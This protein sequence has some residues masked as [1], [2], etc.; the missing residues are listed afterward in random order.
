MRIRSVTAHAFGA[1]EDTTLEFPH[2]L[3]IVVGLNGTGKS[4]WHAAIYAALTGIPAEVVAPVDRR[5]RRRRPRTGS[6]WSVSAEI[7]ADGR[8]VRIAQDLN[9]PHACT[10][11][12]ADTEADLASSIR[13]DGGLDA[14]RWLGLDRRSFAATAYVEQAY[15]LLA[16]SEDS[17][18]KA[19]QRAIASGGGETTVA[20][21]Q[22]RIARH[23]SRVVGE[24]T[25][26]YSPIGR[27]LA[28]VQ[29]TSA[30]QAEHA[31]LS[32]QHRDQQY[33][34]TQ[35]DQE[36]VRAHAD[37]TTG[38]IA[39]ARAAVAE[40]QTR[41]DEA[42]K[43][44]RDHAEAVAF[45]AAR[46]AADPRVEDAAA[47]YR[48]ALSASA[49]PAAPAPPVAP[50][51]VAAKARRSPNVWRVPVVMGLASVVGL[52]ASAVAS[53]PAG[54]IISAMFLL[55]A[56]G[57][58]GWAVLRPKPVPAEPVPAV[59]VPV[60]DSVRSDLADRCRDELRS[61]LH[62]AGVVVAAGEDVWAALE[63]YRSNAAPPVPPYAGP[64]VSDAEVRLEGAR[65][66]LDALQPSQAFS[67]SFGPPVGYGHPVGG[68]G[69]I[70]P[71]LRPAADL[72]TLLSRYEAAEASRSQA[73]AV[74]AGI[75]QQ[76]SVLT[77]DSSGYAAAQA[78]Y[79]RLRHLESIFGEAATRLDSAR[80]SVHRTLAERLAFRVQEWLG[81][82]TDGRY[83]S[84]RIDPET[85]TVYISGPDDPEVD[86]DEDSQGTSDVVRLLLRLALYQRKRGGEA[87]PLLL[88]DV[89]THSDPQRAKRTVEI[90]AKIAKRGHQVIL[91][92]T[93][94]VD[95]FPATVHLMS[96][97]V[98]PRPSG[99]VTP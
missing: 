16:S 49:Q 73:R 67:S 31:E 94:E 18:G 17:I 93:Q 92:A 65:R 32:Q 54:F 10:A 97:Q 30:A 45:A 19:L 82:V 34:V 69:R 70:E 61:A 33:L 63:R 77:V 53:N 50:P 86:S 99:Q 20:E 23:R 43:G 7:E 26:P 5:L 48:S 15:G 76:L 68:Y 12:D 1:I 81:D 85:M 74:L 2:D 21:A 80:A 6:A 55:G 90:L 4:T 24:A 78:E 51:P 87:G 38:Q 57:L 46:P 47:R 66:H 52:A 95:G 91:F 64:S 56:A 36:V 89:L 71:E 59:P 60:P 41:L 37:L 28:A 44:E 96:T 14:T 8:V 58:A 98:A 35:A 75:E 39:A 79:D 40:L 42:I 13:Y 83:T 27:A 88:D 84:V 11:V 62:G 72:P 25:D 22:E 3:N 29:Q 9:R